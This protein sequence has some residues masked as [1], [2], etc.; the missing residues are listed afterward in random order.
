MD[1]LRKVIIAPW[2]GYLWWKTRSMIADE[3]FKDAL[4]YLQRIENIGIGNNPEF[5]LTRGLALYGVGKDNR[6]CSDLSIALELI[7]KKYSYS[8]GDKN[9]L[10]AYAATLLR[11]IPEYSDV[12]GN[13]S[14]L[15][16]LCNLDA[17]KLELVDKVL[18][19]RFPLR[20]HPS[21]VDM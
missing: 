17:I 7:P 6:S 16:D 20:D 2:Y 21:W 3:R 19:R 13:I 8:E 10:T 9:Y 18:K 11:S 14:N 12:D 5:Y 4:S 1:K 15:D